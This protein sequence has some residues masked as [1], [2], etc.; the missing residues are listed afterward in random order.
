MRTYE[1][2]GIQIP[3]VYLPRKGVNMTKWAVIACDQFTSQPEYW[4]KVEKIVGD[5]PSTLHLTL[6]EIYLERPGEEV[7]I[8]SIQAK[9]RTVLE[10]KILVPHEGMVYV[11]RHT[12]KRLRRGLM[13]CLDLECYD[14]TR[15]S[16]SLIRATEGTIIERL[17]PRMKIR[18]GAMLE[19]PHILVLIDDPE[20]TVIEPI[21]ESIEKKQKLYDF[22]LMMDSGRLR[23]YSVS[24]SQEEGI[25]AALRHLARPDI[26]STRYGLEAGK[27]VLLYAMGDGNH[28]LATAKAIWERTKPQAGLDHP[29]RYALV[30]LENVHDEGLVFEPIHRVLFSIR[31]DL[32]VSLRN[33]FQ[34]LVYN[35]VANEAELVRLVDEQNGPDQLVGLAGGGEGRS[36]GVLEIKHPTSNL[37][38]GTLQAFLDVFM[39]ENGADRLDY[40]HGEEVVCR[41]G[42][43]PG[44]AGFYVPGMN[45][46]DLFRTVLLDG[47]LPR[48]T[49]SMGEAKEKRF[50]V[51]A[52]KIV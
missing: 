46:S 13:V 20:G 38:V 1:D 49:F 26:F 25:V 42:T 9:M 31:K 21:S 5:A 19:I 32:L 47:A 8:Q 24:N 18:T 14:Y 41:L 51:E 37:P 30:E 33:H 2:I 44:N 16:C 40:V 3:Q 11:E 50:Y 36:F 52:R 39:K 27:P 45:K 29:S 35:P 4:R 43:K 7:R 22:K 17:P 23:G 28:S 48:K 12:G 6:P 15:D 34:D 10:D